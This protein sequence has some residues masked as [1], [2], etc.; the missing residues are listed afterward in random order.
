MYQIR[1]KYAYLD[2]ALKYNSYA[3]NTHQV[4]V[5]RPRAQIH[6]VRVKY[7]VKYAYFVIT[8]KYRKYGTY[9][10]KYAS[11]LAPPRAPA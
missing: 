3:L 11:Y 5:L 2:C 7:H 4:R 8:H 6:Q 9:M 1:I 10:S